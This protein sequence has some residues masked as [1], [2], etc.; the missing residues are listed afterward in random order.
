MTL[1]LTRGGG[2]AQ[3]PSPSGNNVS[4]YA[5]QP[6]WGPRQRA[7]LRD[8]LALRVGWR[9]FP[10]R[11][12]QGRVAKGARALHCSPPEG[13][14][15]TVGDVQIGHCRGSRVPAL[16]WP[17]RIQDCGPAGPARLAACDVTSW[18]GLGRAC[19][20]NRLYRAWP[21]RHHSQEVPP[22]LTYT[23]NRNSTG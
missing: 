18:T 16:G 17:H 23:L 9:Y 21:V 12:D 11:R 14:V 20:R 8:V 5:G 15:T 6:G 7:P 2:R 4:P 1:L 13:D 10:N 19:V 22:D 3:S